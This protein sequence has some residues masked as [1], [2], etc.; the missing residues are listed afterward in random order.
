[1]AKKV[2]LGADNVVKKLD[3]LQKQSRRRNDVG[4]IVGYTAAYA[5]YVHESVEE[6]LKGQLRAGAKG[7]GRDKKT[8]RFVGGGTYRGRF[9]DPQGRGQAKFLEQPFREMHDELHNVIFRVTKK[10]GIARGNGLDKGLML[11]GLLLQRTSQN[12]VPVDT[13]NLKASAFTRL[14]QRNRGKG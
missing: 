1:M 6:K 12:L 3:W 8:G 4:V 11:A 10:L 9:W 7:G 5:L 2:I 13:G 14:V